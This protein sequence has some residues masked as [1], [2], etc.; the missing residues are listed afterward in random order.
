MNHHWLIIEIKTLSLRCHLVRKLSKNEKVPMGEFQRE[1]V[2]LKETLRSHHLAYNFLRGTPY[3]S[4][5]PTCKVPPNWEDVKDILVR[6]IK[7]PHKKYELVRE[8]SVFYIKHQLGDELLRAFE[9][10]KR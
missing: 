4:I 2:Q 9:K 3:R 5:E 1:L 8:D 7:E 6:F 10:W